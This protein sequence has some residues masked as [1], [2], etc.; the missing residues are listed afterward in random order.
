M[1][2]PIRAAAVELRRR[3]QDKVEV[4]RAT[5]EMAEIRKLY[6][7]LTT[8][9]D[10]LGEPHT[11]LV[12]IFGFTADEKSAVVRF[13]E[14]IG[15][16][17]LVAAKRYLK[18]RDDARPF[19]EIVEM[20]RAGGGKVDDEE[21]LKTGL[22]RSTHDVIKINDRYGLL[23]KYPQVKRGK[24]GKRAVSEADNATAEAQGT[25]QEEGSAA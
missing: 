4:L 3:I 23:E 19:E 16:T 15:L 17:A 2:D 11:A 5:T 22:S 10:V 12:E 8:L 13:D 25:P 7:S 6:Q 14:F 9:E 1:T 20:I 24:V 18:K 21:L